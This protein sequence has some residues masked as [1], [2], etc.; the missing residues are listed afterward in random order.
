MSFCIQMPLT[1]HFMSH[2]DTMLK[3]QLP[4]YC[5]PAPSPVVYFD[6]LTLDMSTNGPIG[7][8]PAVFWVQEQ[9]TLDHRRKVT[10][11]TNSFGAQR[12]LYRPYSTDAGVFLYGGEHTMY[13][14][15]T[16]QGQI[17]IMGVDVIPSYYCF[18]GFPFNLQSIESAFLFRFKVGSFSGIDVA[19]DQGNDFSIVPSLNSSS[20]NAISD[21][22]AMSLNISS[23][24]GLRGCIYFNLSTTEGLYISS[25]YYLMDVRYRTPKLDLSSDTIDV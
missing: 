18:R 12:G 24:T 3:F 8:V 23:S 1:L 7:G 5:T 21:T 25:S 13:T 6:D 16:V 17:M 14:N 15:L 11:K 4:L 19:F 22:L 10:V 20:A 2:H 9:G